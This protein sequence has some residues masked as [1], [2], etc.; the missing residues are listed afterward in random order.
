MSQATQPCT[1]TSTHT[2]THTLLLQLVLTDPVRLYDIVSSFE[3]LIQSYIEL[4]Y[5]VRYLSLLLSGFIR[6]EGGGKE[7]ENSQML[8]VF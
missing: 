3:Q 1:H 2:H 7:G 8:N 6:R 4:A 5:Y